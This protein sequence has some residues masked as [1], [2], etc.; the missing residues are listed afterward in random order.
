[1]TVLGHFEYSLINQGNETQLTGLNGQLLEENHFLIEV[2][3]ERNR[4]SPFPRKDP[5]I[6]W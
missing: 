3:K 1:M 2:R 5:I 4:I 6:L